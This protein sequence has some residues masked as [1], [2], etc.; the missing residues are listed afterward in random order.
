MAAH[1][2]CIRTLSLL[3]LLCADVA[4]AFAARDLDGANLLPGPAPGKPAPYGGYGFIPG[5]P[6]GGLYG[7][8]WGAG[9]GGPAGG[10]AHGGVEV[11]TVVCQEKGPCCG[12]K[13]ACPKKCFWSYSRA[14]NGYGAGGGGGSCTV[15]C[16]DKCTA[17]C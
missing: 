9:Y 5:I 16:K 13:V 6:P 12:K 1:Q 8:G 3:F 14:G 17:Y 4:F 10:Y 7:G 11:P 15:D 2:H